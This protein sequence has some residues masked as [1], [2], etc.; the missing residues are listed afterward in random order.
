MKKIIKIILIVSWMMFIFHMSHQPASV[1]AGQSGRLINMLINIPVIG[2]V[3]SPILTSS[4]G[5]FV[6]RKSAHMFL[7]FILAIL[8]FKLV[9]RKEKDFNNKIIIKKLL[10]SL[11]IVFIYACTDE[12]H[13]LFISGRSGEFRDVM[14]DTVGG[15][16]GLCIMWIYT[17][18]RYAEK[19]SNM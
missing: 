17:K 6:I 9:Y 8:T 3:V 7:Y 19:Q 15:G 16:I 5:E 4:I 14:V 18:M 13:Q 1:S 10:I 12:F 2:N 11:A